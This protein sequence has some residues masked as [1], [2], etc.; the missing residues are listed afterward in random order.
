[1]LLARGRCLNLPQDWDLVVH[2]VQKM[3]KLSYTRRRRNVCF[4]ARLKVTAR[5]C[6]RDPGSCTLR[7]SLDE[8]LA[9]GLNLKARDTVTET[10]L[11]V[12]FLHIYRSP[13]SLGAKKRASAVWAKQEVPVHEWRRGHGGNV[14]PNRKKS[15]WIL[16]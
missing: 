2:V 11:D 7:C 9:E 15:L 14:D 8:G 6:A 1:M 13:T 10:P 16:T 12:R 3:N 4:A 5:L